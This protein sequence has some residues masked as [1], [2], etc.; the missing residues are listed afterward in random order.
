[1]A[2]PAKPCPGGSTGTKSSALAPR[3]TRKV[4]A[5][6]CSFS[7]YTAPTSA[8]GVVGDPPEA[9]PGDLLDLGLRGQ[10][11]GEPVQRLGLLLTLFH[12]GEH[13]LQLGLLSLEFGILLL[14]LVPGR[15]KF[16]GHGVEARGQAAELGGAA[17][18]HP[19]GQ[20]SPAQ[21]AHGLSQPLDGAHHHPVQADRPQ[22][23]QD[24]RG[25]QAGHAEPESQRGVVLRPGPAHAA[26]FLLVRSSVANW[27][28]ITTTGRLAALEAEDPPGRG[29][30][31]PAQPDDRRG[32]AMD[33]VRDRVADRRD[34]GVQLG[35]PR[36]ELVELPYLPGIPGQGGS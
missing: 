7:T 30:V 32:P 8:S 27:S 17:L 36:G 33:V 23:Q 34:P 25:D 22:R 15:L 11:L 35:F 31:R 12:G 13:I 18:G 14:H 21:P 6:A 28:R 24:H 9:D 1:M 20:V 19:G 4:M 3:D 5:P 26:E 10:L 29:Q 16:L 2:R